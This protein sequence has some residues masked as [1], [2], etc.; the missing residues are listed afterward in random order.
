MTTALSF[1]CSGPQQAHPFPL[2]YSEPEPQNPGNLLSRLVRR[3]RAM[4]GI[5]SG[6][7]P[8]PPHSNN[9]QQQ[10]S[11]IILCLYKNIVMS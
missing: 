8:S 6:S 4:P 10:N 11:F 3:D 9:T 1:T 5:G 2:V 7:T